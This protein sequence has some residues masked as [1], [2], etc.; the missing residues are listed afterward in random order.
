MLVEAYEVLIAPFVLSIE[1]LIALSTD[2]KWVI[3]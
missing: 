1:K 2:P 3:S